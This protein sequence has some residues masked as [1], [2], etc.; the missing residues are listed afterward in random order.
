MLI[1]LPMLLLNAGGLSLIALLLLTLA[2]TVSGLLHLALSRSREYAA[3]MSAAQ[4][5]G[6]PGPLADALYRLDRHSRNM[7]RRLPRVLRPRREPPHW[8]STHPS[9]AERIRRLVGTARRSSWRAPVIRGFSE[10]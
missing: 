1:S 7:R 8:L 10:I 3:D 4:L 2:P 9:T 5:M 6:S